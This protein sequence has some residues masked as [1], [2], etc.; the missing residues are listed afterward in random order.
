M[1]WAVWHAGDV[2]GP[3][4][5]FFLLLC[6]VITRIILAQVGAGCRDECLAQDRAHRKRR[7]SQMTFLIIIT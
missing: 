5:S 6:G 3:L 1:E 7:L 4:H 2:L